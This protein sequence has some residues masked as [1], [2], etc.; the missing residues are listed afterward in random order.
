MVKVYC[1][2]E[3]IPSVMF[4]LNPT[5]SVKVTLSQLD[6]AGSE[7]W[8]IECDLKVAARLLETKGPVTGTPVAV[9]DFETLF[10]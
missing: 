8:S 10:A 2:F 9:E 7:F 6:G 4:L 5:E 3:N 1:S